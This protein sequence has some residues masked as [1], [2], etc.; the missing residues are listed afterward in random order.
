[1]TDWAA[2]DRELA[3]WRAE[4]R[5][6]P[7][8][9][10]DDDAVAPS[11]ALDRLLEMA[12]KLSLPVHLA[13]IPAEATRALASLCRDT[14]PVLQHGWAHHNH[15]PDGEKKA[16]FG[17]DRPAPAMCDELSH[18]ASRLRALFG[19]DLLPV[20]VPPWNRISCN[21]VPLLPQAGLS[22]LSTFT[23]RKAATAAPG[24]VQINTHLDPIDWRGTRSAVAFEA[25]IGQLTR[26][27]AQRRMGATDGAE[28][29]GVLTHHLVHDPAIWSAAEALLARLL[30]AGAQPV[31]LRAHLKE[32]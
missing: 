22:A 32:G 30:D 15:A 11:P 24:V 29:Y 7:L 17:T 31:H 26:D 19:D 23:P 14:V 18:G 9:W 25:L 21:L 4:G 20:L 1:M 16:E 12:D 3:L 10:R 28:P 2:L 27:L 8:W 6:L 13:V 5:V